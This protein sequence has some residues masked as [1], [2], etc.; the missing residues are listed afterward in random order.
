MKRRLNLAIVTIVLAFGFQVAQAQRNI[1]PPVLI[2]APQAC[3]TP[4]NNF[5]FTAELSPGQAL[6]ERNEFILELSDPSGSFANQ[7]DITELAR[8]LGPNEAAGGTT[9]ILFSGVQVPA[10]ANSD[11]YRV[12]VRASEA[13]IIGDVSDPI[14][15][16]F[17]DDN[18]EIILNGRDDLIFCSV[19]SFAREIAVEV[20]DENDNFLDVNDF[21][22]EWL[23][24]GAIIPGETSPRLLV[25]EEG[26][27]IA[28]VPLGLCNNFFN[29]SNRSNA[30][31]AVLEN[32]DNFFIETTATDFS[33]CPEEFK[34]L[35]AS[36]I[37]FSYNYQWIKDGE[38]LVGEISPT[39]IL[40]DNNF[41]GEYTLQIV[42]SEDCTLI[43]DPVIVTNEG[44]NITVPLPESLILLPSQSLTLVVETDVPAGSIFRWIAN[45]NVQRQG[46]TAS[47]GETLTFEVPT[48]NIGNY[49]VEIEANDP[50]NS[51][52]FSETDIFAAE[53]FAITIGPNEVVD[54]EQDPITIALIEMVG[55]TSSGEQVPLTTEQFN[56]FNFEWFQDGVST[57]ETSLSLDIS[58][59]DSG[60]TFDLRAIFSPGGLPDTVSN[61]LSIDF[62]SNN[63]VLDITPPV[64][65]AGESVVL[66]GPFSANFTYEWFVILNGEEVLIE[67]E[68]TNTLTVTEEGDY[69]ARISSSLCTTDTLIASVRG[70]GAQ[71]EVIPN[72]ITQ[73][74]GS[75]S[76]VWVLPNSFSDSGVE[77]SIYSSN[78]KLDF[79]K[80][81][82][83]NAD[84]PS[85]SASGADEL[86]YYYI[87]TRNSEVVRKGTITVMR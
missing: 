52:L 33:F 24:D 70:P 30:V 22:W 75:S 71:S 39:I 41:G 26:R 13:D 7:S 67:G 82:G 76:D 87:I 42:L 78:G 20:R 31:D 72:V 34:E 21:N 73:G 79:Q 19:A 80:S 83:Y 48:S 81:G 32:V 46:V 18:L 60:G 44:S 61:E 25:T 59:S 84:W 53:R 43:T 27:Y 68:T 6:P 16:H 11:D 14:P 85:N 58:R 12:R 64:L 69:F 4:A 17:F 8:I 1:K 10:N 47:D 86:I 29:P 37:D 15:F 36:E 45:T 56:F 9:N 54:C 77:V 2:S 49:R 51:M 28:R 35:R 23:K 63:I 38:E 62:L 66:T 5:E 50:C 55:I 74:R 65:E 3:G 57:G 40:P